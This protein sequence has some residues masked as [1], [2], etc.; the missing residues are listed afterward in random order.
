MRSC[1]CR[2]SKKNSGPSGELVVSA[3]QS[4]FAVQGEKGL[5]YIKMVFC[6]VLYFLEPWDLALPWNEYHALPLEGSETEQHFG[7]GNMY[8][9]FHCF[10]WARRM[11][12]IIQSGLWNIARYS[13]FLFFCFWWCHHVYFELSS[14]LLHQLK[15]RCFQGRFLRYG[16]DPA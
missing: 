5:F 10:H 3:R 4:F 14:P 9:D 15:R 11:S 2:A 12:W 13:I 7:Q 8:N 1:L 6:T 16:F